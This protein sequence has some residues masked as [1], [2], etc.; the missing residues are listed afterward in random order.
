[1][2]VE[3]RGVGVEEDVDE[4]F[5][6]GLP[7]DLLRR[8]DDDEA[9]VLVDLAALEDARR[10]AHVLDAAVGAA[11]DDHLVDPDVAGVGRGARVARQVRERDRGNDG[12]GV[13]LD[14]LRVLGVGV[15]EVLDGG[16]ARSGR[17]R[18][19]A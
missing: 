2:G 18:R 7:V 3:T 16:R 17:S 14:D 19:R 10:D 12:G 8:R 1:M 5:V 11:A 4:P 9:H 15:A 6:H 13:D